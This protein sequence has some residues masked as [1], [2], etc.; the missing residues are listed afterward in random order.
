MSA[1]ITVPASEVWEYFQNGKGDLKSHMNQI[2]GNND[3]G[4]AIYVTE[5]SGLPC[6]IV[7]IDDEQYCEETVDSETDCKNTVEEIYDQFL[8]EKAIPLL[9]GELLD[10]TTD[11]E[12]DD[13]IWEH[14]TELDGAVYDFISVAIG[15]SIREVSDFLNDDAIEDI[16]DHFLEYLYRKHHIPIYRPMLLEF[17]D[18]NGE[19]YCE[20]DDYPYDNM[21]FDDDNPIYR[22]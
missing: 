8:Y 7:T 20:Y 17:D 9:T 16:K 15:G 2:A 3:Y 12:Q 13:A 10:E 4:V 1:R 19:A 22:L 5:D 18:E 11:M 21:E 14:E 6:I